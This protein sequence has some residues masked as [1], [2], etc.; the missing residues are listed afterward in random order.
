M[1]SIPVEDSDFFFVPRTLVSYWFQSF[2]TGKTVFIN[3]L[4]LYCQNQNTIF[5]NWLPYISFN[6]S[7][8]NLKVDQAICKRPSQRCKRKN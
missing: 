5:L 1:G 2:T 3:Q 8:E 6:V 7:Y 4:T